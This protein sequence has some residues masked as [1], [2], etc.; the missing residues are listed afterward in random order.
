MCPCRHKSRYVGKCAT[1]V[2][3]ASDG[4]VPVG[5][6]PEVNGPG[7]PHESEFFY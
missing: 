7:R 4:K 6:P 5:E 3:Q 2:G 1:F